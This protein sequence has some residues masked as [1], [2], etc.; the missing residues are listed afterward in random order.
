MLP[1]KEHEHA[2]PL[3]PPKRR[4][5]ANCYSPNRLKGVLFKNRRQRSHF[6]AQHLVSDDEMG[7]VD[8]GTRL[9][10]EKILYPRDVR[11]PR[12]FERGVGHGVYVINSRWP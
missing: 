7:I 3:A 4:T 12:H 10:F 6:L 1:I 5:A 2:S 8:E 11:V 9:S